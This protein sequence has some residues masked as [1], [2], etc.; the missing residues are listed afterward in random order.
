M[1][2]KPKN[3]RSKGF[4]LHVLG[5]LDPFRGSFSFQDFI[6]DSNL[7]FEAGS[8]RFTDI[9]AKFTNVTVLEIQGKPQQLE[10]NI[11]KA[12]P[13]SNPPW[14]FNCKS[15]IEANPKNFSAIHPSGRTKFGAL[16]YFLFHKAKEKS[17]TKPSWYI[18]RKELHY[19]WT[20]VVQPK[21]LFF[22]GYPWRLKLKR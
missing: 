2:T 14:I 10:Q 3:Q 16:W 1:A 7:P 20:G 8:L 18:S 4:L 6:F 19:A 5:E 13:P 9:L 21:S 11:Q 17:C 22:C 12:E 15:K